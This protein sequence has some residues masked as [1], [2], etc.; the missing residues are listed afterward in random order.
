M[1]TYCRDC[2]EELTEDNHKKFHGR[3]CRTCFSK[4]KMASRKALH[5]PKEP[6][7]A[8]TCCVE[9]SEIFTEDNHK[10]W[11]GKYCKPCYNKKQLEKRRARKEKEDP[12]VLEIRKK[13]HT[14]LERIRIQ[15]PEIRDEINRR[16]RERYA[17]NPSFRLR[18]VLAQRI[19]GVFRG[20][21]NKAE[22]TECLTG[23][24][25]KR[26]QEWI[27]YQLKDDMTW[28]NYGDEWEIDHVIPISSFDLTDLDQQKECFNW[29][30][31]APLYITENRSKKDKIIS[32]IKK[33]HDS[34]VVK[35][36]KLNPDLE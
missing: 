11:C 31:Q 2:E 5:P 30:N 9:C 16:R 27:E 36:K 32:S 13:R 29:K 8:A 26:F 7:K 3:R 24:P 21:G 23:I 25:F 1:T 35:F 20:N 15:R 12:E 10:T 28:D 17:T 14:E 34:V 19:N 6:R 22:S 33:K 18:I 4:S